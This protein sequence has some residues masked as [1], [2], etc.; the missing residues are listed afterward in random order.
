[1]VDFA[2]YT[3]KFSGTLLSVD[4]FKSLEPR[5][6]DYVKFYLGHKFNECDAVKK[7]I[8]AV[9]E[10]YFKLDGRDGIKSETNDGISRT[11]ETGALSRCA[12]GAIAVY[13]ADTGLLYRGI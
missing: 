12:D 6:S 9:C 4:D 3:E 8:C 10:V 11:F 13:L 1:M 5:A 7:A 2:F